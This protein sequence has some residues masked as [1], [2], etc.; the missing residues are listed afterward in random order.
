[1]QRNYPKVVI[2]K[3][4]EEWLNKGQM[5]MYRNNA[6]NL[7][8]TI[9]NGSV[10]DIVTTQGDYMGT[11]FVSLD[12]HITVRIL[13]KDLHDVFDRAFFK[14]RIQFAYAFRKTLEAENLTNCRL[15]FGEADQLPGLTVD[16][17]ND[18]LVA[19]ISSFGMDKIKDM[20]YEVLLEV[21]KED[22]QD[23]KGIYE[24]NDIKVRTKEGLPLE[25]GYWRQAQLPTKTVINENGLLL[26]V[27][28]E[29]GQKTGYFLDQKSNRV[30]LRKMAHGKRVMDCFTHTGGFAL[31]AA[32]GQALEV[33]AVDVSQT[34]LDQAYEN[35]KLNHLEDRMSFVK[36][37][38]FD[39]LDECESGRFDI[40]VL[41]PPA[42]TKSRRTIDHA[43][44][45]YKKINMK[46][47]KLLGKG[48]YLITCS[49]S[50]F[51]E[52]DNFEKMLREAAH[53]S[54]VTLKQVSVT[55]QNH[56]HPIL[57]TMEE[58]SY[59]KFYIFQII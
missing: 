32:Y 10:V 15:I 54:G 26:N 9:E 37:D 34:A 20:L 6:V 59:L 53:E 51:M 23:V 38:V 8:E 45:G 56:D 35:A 57:W 52:I 36:A 31:N 46:A 5:W 21:L 7:D 18:I 58:T 19:Q 22:G 4:G 47:M 12:S 55:Q 50:R 1:M 3:E 49:C 14:Q 24:R 43:Y 40:I 29:N 16:R 39:Y 25:K 2:S 11:G 33:V 30:L 28:V 44:S 48:G 42:F 27:D 17:Y 13:S 41:D